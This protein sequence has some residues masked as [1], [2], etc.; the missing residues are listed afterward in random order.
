MSEMRS[1]FPETTRQQPSETAP[2]I[3]TVSQLNRVVRDLL[4]AGL[5]ALWLEGEISNFTHH[6]NGHMY[7]TQR[8]S[9]RDRSRDVLRL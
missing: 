3:F 5:P 1:L 7:F 8:R 9:R 2:T 4:E 6:R